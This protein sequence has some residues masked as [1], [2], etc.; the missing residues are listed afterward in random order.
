MRDR[1]RNRLRVVVRDADF[2]ALDAGRLGRLFRLAIELS[3]R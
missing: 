3:T 1:H 2:D